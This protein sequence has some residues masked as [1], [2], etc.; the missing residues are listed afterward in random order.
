MNLEDFESRRTSGFGLVRRGYDPG[1]VD[2]FLHEVADW[3]RG[4]AAEELGDEAVARKLQLAG[5]ST[6][7]VLLIA[8]REAEEL[9]RDS[10]ATF[11]DLRAQVEEAAREE[12]ARIVHL[13][14][15]EAEELRRETERECDDL[16][17]RTYAE[18]NETCARAERYATDVAAKADEEARQVLEEAVVEARSAAL[19]ETERLQAE[20]DVAV[21]DLG[22]RRNAA[23]DE[24]ERLRADLLHAISEH[25]SRVEPGDESERRHTPTYGRSKHANA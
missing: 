9:R 12:A 22:R 2:R 7:R 5:Q 11:A 23:V 4:D 25:T 15:E 21:A 3:L 13:A 24:V 19:E 14:E 8:E 10:Q 1:E 17:T 16:R 18:A 20:V 6:A